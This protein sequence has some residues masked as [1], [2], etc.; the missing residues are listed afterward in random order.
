MKHK[1]PNK[2]RNPTFAARFYIALYLCS[3]K[4]KK[5]QNMN[6]YTRE[7]ITQG[8]PGVIIQVEAAALRG[9]VADMYA[10]EQARTATAIAEHKKQPTI[11]RAEAAKSL[12]VALSTLS[13]WDKSGYLSPVK[14]G[15]KVLYKA[16]DIDRL[17]TTRTKRSNAPV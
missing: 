1:I 8:A 10:Q 16:S 13:N 2:K 17:L 9:I 4:T 3:V 12:N 11:T 15:R 14:I 7:Q 6:P 5:Q